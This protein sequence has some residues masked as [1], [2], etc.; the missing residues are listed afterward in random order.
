LTD[1]ATVTVNLN[2]LIENTAP[3]VN[4]QVFAV[5]ENSANGTVVGTV[6]ASDAEGDPLNY[7]ITAGNTGGA[8]AIGAASGALT[9]ANSAALDFETTP[10]F[11][12]T[13]QVSDG[14][15]TDTAT[16]T[17]NLNDLNDNTAPVD[18]NQVFPV[19]E[20]SAN[21]TLDGKVVASDA[22]ADQMN[23]SITAGN[24]GGAFA[25]GAAS[26]TLT[27]ANSAALDFETSPSFAL[28]VQGSDGALTDTATVTVNLNDLFENT[29]PVVNNQV[30]AV[31]ENSANG[32]VVG[33]VGACGAEAD[34]LR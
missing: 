22:E 4:N 26:G 1:T 14:S 30:V 15:L 27:V 21:G 3:V 32:T 6:V 24:T 7:S 19:N 8:F 10:S 33:T 11:A 13:V 5:N 25:I 16:V 9:V 29:A 12:L 17:V 20:N 2:D 31:N 28:T 23:Y 34:P 18:N